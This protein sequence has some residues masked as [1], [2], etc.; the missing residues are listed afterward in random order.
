[1]ELMKDIHK[2]FDVPAI[3]LSVNGHEEVVYR[4]FDMSGQLR[5]QA[6]LGDE[7]CG[8]DQGGPAQN[9]LRR[10]WLSS[11]E[12]KEDSTTPHEGTPYY[13]DANDLS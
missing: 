11:Q 2:V 8:Q 1:M 7:A 5:G 9:V 12:K 6:L 3:F 13:D 4:T 10:S